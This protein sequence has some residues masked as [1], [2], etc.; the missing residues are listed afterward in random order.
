MVSTTINSNKLIRKAGATL[1][2]PDYIVII[3]TLV[4][5]LLLGIYYGIIRRKH[6]KSLEAYF[7]GERNMGILP[8]TISLMA[9]FYSAILL[10]G[11]P[12]EVH[13]QSGI[14][15]IYEGLGA[16]VGTLLAGFTFQPLLYKAGVTTTFEVYPL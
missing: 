9:T 5:V 1:A 12:G 7:L 14:M 15:M 3:V 13:S 2:W 4:G 6:S 11:V 16:G 10:L 8:V